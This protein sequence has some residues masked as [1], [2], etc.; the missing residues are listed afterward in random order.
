MRD[1]TEDYEAEAAIL[2]REETYPLKKTFFIRTKKN[3]EDELNG[4]Q[5]LLTRSSSL[6]P[7]KPT[8]GKRS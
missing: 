3:I 2:S 1:T 6:Q 8:G 4:G 5:M 7:R